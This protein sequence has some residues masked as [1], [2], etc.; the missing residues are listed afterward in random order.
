MRP[1]EPGA[2]THPHA[3][4][5][6]K[7]PAEMDGVLDS[8]PKNLYHIIASQVCAVFKI[9]TLTKSKPSKT[10]V[11]CSTQPVSHLCSSCLLV[12]VQL[13]SR[14]AHLSYAA[15][16]AHLSPRAHALVFIFTTSSL[17]NPPSPTPAA[18]CR[19][20]LCKGA[21]PVGMPCVPAARPALRNGC[22]GGWR[23]RGRVEPVLA[24]GRR[25]LL[26]RSLGKGR[27]RQDWGC[28]LLRL[29][30]GGR[31]AWWCTAGP[32]ATGAPPCGHR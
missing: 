23:A 14:A 20:V 8:S 29:P 17:H 2:H 13:H 6:F 31:L 7:H 22:A 4:W 11:C 9:P 12:V 5:P 24:V 1:S 19:A 25:A 26:A 27:K 18:G 10:P 15:F 16:C 32:T 30:A 28:R 21:G 3:L